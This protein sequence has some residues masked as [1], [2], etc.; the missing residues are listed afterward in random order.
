MADDTT[1]PDDSRSSARRRTS[2][3]PAHTPATTPDAPIFQLVYTSS[4]RNRYIPKSQIT[5]ILAKSRANNSHCGVTGLLLYRDGSF[6]QFLEGPQDEVERTFHRIEG[7]SRHSGV[8]VVLRRTVE[9][10]DFKEWTMG[11]R[12][13]DWERKSN[14]RDESPPDVQEERG[15]VQRETDPFEVEEHS[16]DGARD[17]SSIKE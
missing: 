2:P 7:D 14:R 16:F 17:I 13:L 15:G 5:S 4:A 12:D 9:R 11:F 10:R 1:L 3:A 8:I 6:A